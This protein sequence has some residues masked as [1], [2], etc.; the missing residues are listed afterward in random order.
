MTWHSYTIE[1]LQTLD[2]RSLFLITFAVALLCFLSFQFWKQPSES[3]RANWDYISQVIAR[4]GVPYRDVVNIKTPLSAYIGAAAIVTARPFGL[5]DIFAIRIAYLL[6]A[7]LTVSFTLLAALDYFGSR[8]VAVLAAAIMV[9]FKIFGETNSG[10]VQPKTPMVLF[11]LMSLCT[12]QR[13]RAFLAGL[14]GMLSALSWQPGLLFVG[15]AI[16]AFSRY[17]TR[18]RDL[19]AVKVVAGAALPLAITVAYFWS[20]GALRDFYLWNIDFNYNVY[21]PQQARSFTGFVDRIARMM[22]GTFRGEQLYFY[23]AAAA[24]AGAL[25]AELRLVV[26]QSVPRLL[27]RAVYHAI[28]ISPAVYFLFCMI[29]IQGAADLIPLLPFVAIFAAVALIWSV[30]RAARTLS[31]QR[32][33][34]SRSTAEA[35]A[36][37]AVLVLIL[38]V[39]SINGLL[40]RVG[41]PTL[42][43]Q[44]ADIAQM[45]S[46]LEPGDRV[47]VQGA[48]QILV[49]SGLPNSSKHY[50][51]DR[52]KD[53]YLDKVEPGGFAGWFARLKAERPKLVAIDRTKNVEH[54]NEFADWM[55]TDYEERSGSVFTYYLRRDPALN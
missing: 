2:R 12:I 21:G 42:K 18:W 34:S 6:L 1:R 53:S 16:L 31:R 40:Y 55:L 26:K 37:A 20:T 22:I 8:R 52:G 45:T 39:N 36:F 41:F 32:G 14:L 35:W 9:A 27:D 51:L 3:D 44:D 15:V 5:R 11:G 10:G 49:V 13:D 54:R 7:A 46:H 4:G 48:A 30:D 50:F 43:D 19:N 25:W 47:F 24:V 28:L 29:N 23:L 38:I 17:L 33:E